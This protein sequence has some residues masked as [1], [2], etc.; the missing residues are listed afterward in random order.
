MT[1]RINIV[2]SGR[3]AFTLVELLVVI[4]I[5]G[6][7]VALLLPAVQAARSAARN[8]QCQN[9]L[10]QIGLATLECEHA[11]QA[12]PPLSAE[13]WSTPPSKAAPPYRGAKKTGYTV[14]C[15]LLPYIDQAGLDYGDVRLDVDGNLYT[16]SGP[17]VTNWPMFRFVIET[18][19]C[20]E[21]PSPSGLTGRGGTAWGRANYFGISNYVGNFLVLGN[22]KDDSPEGSTHVG[23][24]ADGLSNTIFFSERYATCSSVSGSDPNDSNCTTVLASLWTG[25]DDRWGPRFCKLGVSP[26]ADGRPRCRMFQV[27]PEWLGTCD[28]TL[29][30][31]PHASGINAGLGDGSVRFINE[32]ISADSWADLCDPSDGNL[33][34]NDW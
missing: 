7:L 27:T 32:S 26:G 10:K 2:R 6:I 22:P 1:G 34:R 17:A 4:T 24:I 33:S 19:R 28:Y 25:S 3:G 13:T 15:Y 5:I 31:S 14:L 9:K 20:P 30:S 18:Y 11:N 29:A 12:F 8:L 23:D 21:E 16:L